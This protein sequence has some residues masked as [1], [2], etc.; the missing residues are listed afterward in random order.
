MGYRPE[1]SAP[2][3]RALQAY[4]TLTVSLP[5]CTL[6][7]LSVSLTICRW[8]GCFDCLIISS[9]RMRSYTVRTSLVILAGGITPGTK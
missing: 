8:A 5:A 4:Y 7:A 1:G 6:K 3:A 2:G 9:M